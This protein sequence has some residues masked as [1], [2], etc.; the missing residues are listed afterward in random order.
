M[1]MKNLSAALWWPIVLLV[2]AA[3]FAGTLLLSVGQSI[4]FDE[5]YSILLAKSSWQ[6]LFALTAVD[7]HPPLY[8]ALLKIWGSLFGFTELAL[9]SMS[10]VFL[11]GSVIGIAVL[12]R[13]L[14]SARVALLVLPFI[15][16]APFLL[17]YGYEVRMYSTALFI[18]VVATYALVVALQNKKWWQWAIY[19]ALVALGMYTLYMM[20]AIWLAH[21]VWLLVQSLKK[22]RKKLV[23][24]Q[25]LYAYVG[26]VLLFAPYIPTFFNQMLHSA[27][28]GIGNE[29]TLT[30]LVDMTTVLLTFTS[31]WQI[32]GWLTLA[33]IAGIGATVWVGVR[34]R[35][36]LSGAEKLHYSLLVFLVLVP[37]AFYAV[38]SLPPRDPIFVNRYLAHSAIFIYALLG[39]TLAL[40]FVYRMKLK[41]LAWMPILAYGIMLALLALGVVRLQLTGNFVFERNQLPQTQELRADIECSDDV[42]IVADDPYTFID[43]VFYFDGCDLRFFSE[44][45]V[46]KRGGYAPLHDSPLRIASSEEVTSPIVIRLGWDGAKRQFV[47]DDRYELHSSKV[48]DKQLVETYLLIAE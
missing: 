5:G 3:A 36:Y 44:N 31:E 24:W 35:R 13:K 26:A 21:A 11:A 17:R 27:L 14:F 42:T 33:I 43:S 18:G 4:W 23:E 10:A 8:Y 6:E 39:I 12:L 32:G 48:Y 1:K 29:I 40:G 46:E 34:T 37:L 16:F 9:R 30:R 7:A 25:W 45:P 15:L 38:T 19:A 2:A 28:P 20:M 41:R 22:P 47:P